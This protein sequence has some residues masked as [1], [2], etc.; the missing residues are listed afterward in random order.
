VRRLAVALVSLVALGAGTT[1]AVGSVSSSARAHAATVRAHRGAVVPLVVGVRAHP[2]PSLLPSLRQ[3]A[4][5][6]QHPGL[7]L[8]PRAITPHAPSVPGGSG[9]TCY[10]AANEGSIQPCVEFAAS[11]GESTMLVAQPA[12]AVTPVARRAPTTVTKTVRPSGPRGQCRSVAGPTVTLRAGYTR[13][14]PSEPA[15]ALLQRPAVTLSR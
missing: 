12:V 11:G 9:G 10:V 15:A 13:I 3:A 2:L 14:A 4:A 1:V 6:L 7:A 5:Q 8:P